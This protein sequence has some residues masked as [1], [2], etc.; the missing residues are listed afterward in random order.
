MLA[1][2]A[3]YLCLAGAP[4]RTPLLRV[5]V[6]KDT[7]SA[8]RANAALVKAVQ[9]RLPAVRV[10]TQG[11]LAPEDLAA[12]LSSDEAGW[13][14]EVRRFD[15]QVAMTR[16]LRRL[17]C[18]QVGD[19]SALILERY[20]EEIAW[21]G[22]S[23]G[24]EPLPL[25]ASGART[26]VK[27]DSR[28]PGAGLNPTPDAGRTAGATPVPSDAG[29]TL[30]GSESADAGRSAG[31]TV[32][33]SDAGPTLA[34]S[35]SADAGRSAGATVDPSD[36]EP[37]LA[38][39]ESADAGRSVGATADPS[40]AGPAS[41]LVA[42][43]PLPAAA[44]ALPVPSPFLTQLALYAG[45]G[46]W[47]E[48]PLEAG[49]ALAVELGAHVGR[50]RGALL[51]VAG[52]PVDH[53][54]TIDGVERG[55]ISVQSFLAAATATRCFFEGWS[56]CGG[57]IAGARFTRGTATGP[58]LYRTKTS[59]VSLPE[60]GLT[61]RLSRPLVGRLEGSLDLSA[62]APLGSATFGIEGSSTAPRRTPDVDFVSTV[63]LGRRGAGR[64]PEEQH[65]DDRE[66][67]RGG[68]AELSG[69]G[70]SQ[71]TMSA[72]EGTLPTCTTLP[73]TTTPGVVRR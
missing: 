56:L 65:R 60:L 46:G 37:T 5:A 72:R 14:L 8:C 36:A 34:G 64:G 55:A 63:R 51:F 19:T 71:L 68:D 57:V 24:I 22:R 26:Q 39:S 29:P 32:D 40:D 50:W 52:A 15:G 10:A 62:A 48:S 38:G 44:A 21:R 12:S 47:L 69:H 45:A 42:R 6:E 61:G 11:A 17:E 67:H 54:V 16:T 73:S 4:P 27:P 30:A 18:S 33:P 59:L 66:R 13:H 9:T 31:A 70:W 25:P 20:L 49:P 28:R 23:V 7:P 3:T 2:V 43:T 41:A 35:E 53:P 1:L 58:S